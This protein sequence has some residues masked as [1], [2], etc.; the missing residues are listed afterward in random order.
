MV[1]AEQTEQK[2]WKHTLKG[3]LVSSSGNIQPTFMYESQSWKM[4][5]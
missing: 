5:H 4:T 3:Y 2:T 1:T